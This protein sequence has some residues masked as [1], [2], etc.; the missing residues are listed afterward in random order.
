METEKSVVRSTPDDL[1]YIY[2]KKAIDEG[3]YKYLYCI[4]EDRFYIYKDGYWQGLHELE[5]VDLIN[6]TVRIT[7][8]TLNQTKNITGQMKRLIKIRL[9]QFNT[10]PLFNLENYMI[11]PIGKNVLDHDQIYYSTNRIP[12][13]YDEH[14][15]CSLWLKTLDE[16]FEGNQKKISLLQEFFG[17]C[18]TQEIDQKKA[19]LLLGDSDSGKSTILFTL[20]DLLGSKNC[21]SVPLKVLSNPQYTPLLVNKLVNIDADVDKSAANYEA[22]FKIITSGEPVTCNQKFIETF[23]FIPKCKIVLAANTFPR[24][25]DHSSAFYKR[26]IL[27]PC[28]RIFPEE[29]QN[30]NLKYQLKEELPGILNW[31]ITGQKRLKQRGRFEQHDFMRDAVQELE[32]ENNPVNNFFDEHIEIDISGDAYI[33]KGELYEKFKA[34]TEETNNCYKLNLARFSQCVFKKYHKFTPKQ[35]SHPLTHKRIWRS[36]RYVEVK[37]GQIEMAKVPNAGWQE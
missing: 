18:L 34:W 30:K 28:E 27:I 15:P 2:A 26:L 23:E 37:S 21:S 29:A 32:D 35:T 13:R 6:E 17:Y 20:R 3:K 8:L 31:V 7:H 25:T 33:E 1:M 4:E 11:D 10:Y 14:A 5:L 9:D 16:I 36:L 12:Y 24:I 22:E 19:L